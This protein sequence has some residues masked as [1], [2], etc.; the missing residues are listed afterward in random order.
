MNIAVLGFKGGVG[1]TTTA[2]HLALYL[3][4]KQG[5]APLGGSG[6]ALLIDADPNRSASR[7]AE[8]GSSFPI[9]VLAGDPT[10]PTPTG[11]QHTVIDTP[12]RPTPEQLPKNWV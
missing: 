12:A 7:W 11:F 4:Q 2:V 10:T 9:K 8:R 3:Q 6:M 1:K 5:A